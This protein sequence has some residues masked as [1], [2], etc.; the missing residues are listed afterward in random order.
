MNTT[1]PSEKVAQAAILVAKTAAKTA[2][3]VAETVV[4]N[5]VLLTKDIENIKVHMKVLNDETGELRDIVKEIKTEL[6]GKAIKNA[7]N[8]AGIHVSLSTVKND[9]GWLKQA[10][11]LVAGSSVS[12]VIVG[13]VNLYLNQS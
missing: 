3:I 12:A 1:D 9:V 13:I 2:K 7:D 10:F 6:T 5:S 8:I 11:W 4:K